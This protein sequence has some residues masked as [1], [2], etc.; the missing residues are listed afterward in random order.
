MGGNA[1]VSNLISVSTKRKIYIFMYN[2]NEEEILYRRVCFEFY[3]HEIIPL[4]L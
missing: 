4:K 1:F 2:R 3:R